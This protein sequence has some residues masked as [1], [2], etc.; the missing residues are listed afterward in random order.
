[1]ASTLKVNRDV[2][3]KFLPDHETIIQFEDLFKA[4]N[5]TN[6]GA[7]VDDAFN[8]ADDALSKA[9]LGLALLGKTLKETFETINENLKSYAKS[10]NY[11]GSR[12]DSVVYS[13]GSKT[14]TKTLTYTGL[15]LLTVALSGNTPSSIKLTKTLTYSGLNLTGVAYT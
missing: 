6:N 1:M 3:A 11:T 12:L 7:E 14:I 15:Q 13:F 10:F 5:D 4:V 9:N 8:V 2:F